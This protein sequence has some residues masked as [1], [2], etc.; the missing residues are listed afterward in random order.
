[1]TGAQF[2]DFLCG[3]SGQIGLLRKNT[4]DT[5]YRAFM[6][7]CLNLVLKDIQTKQVNWHWR[8]LERIAV[9][10]TVA[11]QMDYSLPT[12]S[13]GSAFDIDTHKVFA[14]YDRTQDITYHYTPYERFIRLVAD[15]TNNKG[16]SCIWT[17]WAN[18]LKL[19]PVPIAYTFF[20]AHNDS[21]ALLHQEPFPKYYME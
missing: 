6:L 18:K 10:P 3:K 17:L 9:A 20:P 4:G 19:Y 11:D 21:H 5:S 15:P 8:F 12:I 7:E 1:M 13:G 14:V 2:L 16:S